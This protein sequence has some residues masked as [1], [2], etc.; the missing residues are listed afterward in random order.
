M[1]TQYCFTGVQAAAEIPSLCLTLCERNQK[2]EFAEHL[3]SLCVH[4]C[5][6]KFYARPAI[7]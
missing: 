6:P 3:T 5:L 7:A 2:F 4:R 1:V